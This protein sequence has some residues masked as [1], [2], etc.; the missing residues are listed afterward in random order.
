MQRG[1]KCHDCEAGH[2]LLTPAAT[3]SGPIAKHLAY[4]SARGSDARLVV[5]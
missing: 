2:E 5:Y 4:H 1:W 3:H